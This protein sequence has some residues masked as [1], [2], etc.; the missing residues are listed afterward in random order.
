MDELKIVVRCFDPRPREG[1]DIR[2]PPRCG[3]A[4]CFDPRLREGGE[5]FLVG[6]WSAK[7]NSLAGANLSRTAAQESGSDDV[8]A[9]YIMFSM[10]YTEREPAGILGHDRG[11]RRALA[12][13]DQRPVQV[14][15]SRTAPMVAV[16]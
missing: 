9:N 13:H 5:A 16:L 3:L 15:S 10:C 14:R 2:W 7:E 8:R 1:G 12:S 11:S 4:A 6:Q